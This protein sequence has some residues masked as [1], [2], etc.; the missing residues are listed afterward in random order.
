MG[1]QRTAVLSTIT[2]LP[3][4]TILEIAQFADIADL[5]ALSLTC[6][7]LQQLAGLTYL[8]RLQVLKPH[9]YHHAINLVYDLPPEVLPILFT[10]IHIKRCTLRIDLPTIIKHGQ[11]LQPFLSCIPTISDLRIIVYEEHKLLVHDTRQLAEVLS[12]FLGS[13]SGHHCLDFSIDRKVSW[14]QRPPYFPTYPRL[15]AQQG[16]LEKVSVFASTVEKLDLPMD[17]FKTTHLSHVALAFARSPS[18]TSLN[19]HSSDRVSESEFA[20][21]LD[22]FHLPALEDLTIFGSMAMIDLKNFLVRHPQV[23][24]VQLGR[25][26]GPP[27]DDFRSDNQYLLTSVTDVIISADYV[28]GFFK[29]FKLP[30]LR[31]LLIISAFHSISALTALSNALDTISV[32]TGTMLSRLSIMFSMSLDFSLEDE[33]AYDRA[34]LVV[35][36]PKRKLLGI[37]SLGVD[38]QDGLESEASMVSIYGFIIGHI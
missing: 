1:V 36:Y 34:T 12:S 2:S 29:A 14:P 3:N 22:Q 13:L 21:A 30:Y 37:S 10:M 32:H 33:E 6:P 24:Q 26:L 18:I 17:M 19:L 31:S 9:A 23:S 25:C 20:H 8:E 38:F 5:P 15:D 11:Q 4:E 16:L 7:R 28:A 27:S 35:S